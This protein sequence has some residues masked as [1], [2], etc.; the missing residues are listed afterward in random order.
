MQESLQIIM[1]SLERMD[2]WKI[3]VIGVLFLWAVKIVF[4]IFTT[5]LAFVATPWRRIFR[6]RGGAQVTVDLP[7]NRVDLMPLSIRLLGTG[8]TLLLVGLAVLLC[9]VVPMASP[10]VAAGIVLAALGAGLLVFYGL[11][12][13][14]EK[15]AGKE[16]R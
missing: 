12:Y 15:R 2:T 14:E 6:Q 8:T 5:G 11:V 13:R 9:A 7:G 1:T 3:L 16:F 4:G 10:W